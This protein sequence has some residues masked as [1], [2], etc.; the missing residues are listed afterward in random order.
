MHYARSFLYSGSL[1]TQKIIYFLFRSNLSVLSLIHEE[2]KE[3]S[4]GPKH[5]KWSAPFSP[6]HVQLN[7]LFLDLVISDKLCSTKLHNIPKT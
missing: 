3:I 6:F 7:D 1:F 5:I 4:Q 2:I